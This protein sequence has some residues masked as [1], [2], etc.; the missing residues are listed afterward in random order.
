MHPPSNILVL[1]GTH[2]IKYCY[3]KIINI[4]HAAIYFMLKSNF[5]NFLG[6]NLFTLVN[7]KKYNTCTFSN[8]PKLI[9]VKFKND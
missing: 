2:G 4:I 9:L 8:H 7:F 1:K 3:M 5:Y 6:F